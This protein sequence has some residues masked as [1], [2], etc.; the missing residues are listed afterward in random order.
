MSRLLEGL[1]EDA[2][3]S[4]FLF[5]VHLFAT[6]KSSL[7]LLALPAIT[8]GFNFHARG[9]RSLRPSSLHHNG[10]STAVTVSTAMSP[11]DENNFDVDTNDSR[12][13]ETIDN[14]ARKTKDW[15]GRFFDIFVD[16]NRELQDFEEYVPESEVDLSEQEIRKQQEFTNKAIDF[17]FE[18]GRDL[19][20]LSQSYPRRDYS[21]SVGQEL[22]FD[23][24]CNIVN[25]ESV[26]QIMMELP[27]VILEDVGIKVEGDALVV[28]GRRQDLYKER[29]ASFSK[30]FKLEPT[31]DTSRIDAT[32]EN[33]ILTVVAPKYQIKSGPR[34]VPISKG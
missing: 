34:R 23:P 27:G 2:F 33:G 8:P 26:Y 14:F 32:M 12:Q 20:D 22:K 3:N 10:V 4:F 16:I 5:L 18:L 7:V 24:V 31:I 11:T 9:C 21:Q 15:V 1:I 30:T 6:M 28:D 25:N 29:V 17:A 19:S 13:S